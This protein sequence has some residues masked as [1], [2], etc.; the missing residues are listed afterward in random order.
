LIEYGKGGS[1]ARK[2]I[3][4][5]GLVLLMTASYAAQR[6]VICEELYQET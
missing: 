5:L 4:V 2:V 1:M 6:V 3:V